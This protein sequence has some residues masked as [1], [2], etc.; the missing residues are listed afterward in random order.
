MEDHQ[1][2]LVGGNAL[3]RTGSRLEKPD[4]IGL[5]EITGTVIRTGGTE[6]HSSP[7]LN[8][9][10]EQRAATVETAIGISSGS[11]SFSA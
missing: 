6:K 9:L 5:A 8:E 10:L 11:A 1:L 7:E 4:Q 3:I 2:P